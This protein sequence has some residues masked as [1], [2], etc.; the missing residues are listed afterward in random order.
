MPLAEDEPMVQHPPAE[1]PESLADH[2]RPWRLGRGLD[3]PKAVG[4]EHLIEGRGELGVPVTDQEPH[5]RAT[6]RRCRRR[7]AAEVT[8]NTADQRR[9]GTSRDSTANQIRSAGSYRGR[10]T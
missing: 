6:R 10:G 7:I 2:V 3:D 8:E 4:L 5:L 9:R 1:R